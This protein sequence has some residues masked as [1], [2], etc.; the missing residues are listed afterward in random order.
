MYIIEVQHSSDHE[1][2]GIWTP[3]EYCETEEFAQYLVEFFTVVKKHPK[4]L[5]P[6]NCTITGS[7]AGRP[8]RYR[9]M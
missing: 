3:L 6:E 7:Y 1:R 5:R 9:K 2:D 4:G 8:V